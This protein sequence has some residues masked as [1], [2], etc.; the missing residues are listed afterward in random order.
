MDRGTCQATVHR[1]AQSQTHCSHL[2]LTQGRRLLKWL[3]GKESACQCR[4]NRRCRF[5]PWVRKIS[6]RRKWQPTPVFLPG[7]SSWTEEPGGLQ[8]LGSRRV[9]LHTHALGAGPLENKTLG[10]ELNKRCQ[11]STSLQISLTSE[12]SPRKPHAALTP[13]PRMKCD[14]CLL[15]SCSLLCSHPPPGVGFLPCEPSSVAGLE[16]KRPLAP[17]LSL[18]HRFTTHWFSC[19]GELGTSLYLLQLA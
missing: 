19:C 6:W 16:I 17:N 18:G 11:T 10:V 4:R 14:P 12:S 3:S 5:S 8:F 1:V 13:P 2:A 9:G 15:L 7:K